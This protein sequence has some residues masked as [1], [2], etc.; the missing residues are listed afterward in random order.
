MSNPEVVLCAAVR[1]AIGSY[2]GALKDLPATDLG[3]V[4]IR[5]VLARTGLRGDDIDTVVMGQVVQAGA[6][7]ESRAPGRNCGGYR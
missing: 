5:E 3:A 7:I 1:T 6:K 2:A 4:A